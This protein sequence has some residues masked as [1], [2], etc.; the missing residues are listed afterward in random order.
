MQTKRIKRVVLCALSV[1]IAILAVNLFLSGRQI[2]EQESAYRAART[3]YIQLREA[4]GI[5]IDETYQVEGIDWDALRAINPGVVGW[6]T[7]PGTQINYPITQGVDNAHYLYHTFA[8]VRNSSGAVFLHYRAA[9]DFSGHVQ[10]FA[11]NMRDGS[12]F[13]GLHGWTG[14][15]FRIY[16]PDGRM[17]TFAVTKRKVVSVW[18][19]VFLSNA[20][21]TLLVTCVSGRPDVRLVVWS[22]L[23]NEERR[24]SE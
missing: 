6:I 10:L 23:Q 3:E 17:L 11:H 8:G 19:D 22:E 4:A 14:D 5:A 15:T 1:V 13:A 7:V 12:M 16:T 21:G 2:V 20:E 24:H 9:S 18:S